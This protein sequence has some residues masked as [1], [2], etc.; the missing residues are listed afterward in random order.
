MELI[1][2]IY[3][4][5]PNWIPPIRMNQEELVGFRPHPFYEN[6]KCRAFILKKN[7]DVIGRI[8]GDATVLR[9]AMGS[10]RIKVER[11]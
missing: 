9:Q 10:T 6:A 3:K 1:W 8:V 11:A 4:G 5:D 2:R 7:G